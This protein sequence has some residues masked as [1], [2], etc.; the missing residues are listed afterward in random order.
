[1]S[2]YYLFEGQIFL[3]PQVYGE[4]NE[5]PGV[6]L[7]P[8]DFL[9]LYVCCASL[10]LIVFPV[11]PIYLILQC[12]HFIAYMQFFCIVCKYLFY[13]VCGVCGAVPDCSG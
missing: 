10:H 6:C 13:Y 1:M 8:Y 2:S 7:S 5:P 9:M 4:G 3:V 11:S 12:L